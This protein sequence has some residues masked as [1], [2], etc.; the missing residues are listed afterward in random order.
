MTNRPSVTCVCDSH[1]QG[2][3][4]SFDSL[5]MLISSKLFHHSERSYCS[6]SLAL[7][8]REGAS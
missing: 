7:P 3:G 5:T 6:A 2:A 4:D 1:G 8:L